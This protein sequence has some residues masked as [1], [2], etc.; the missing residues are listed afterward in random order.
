M[1]GD[2]AAWNDPII[3]QGLAITLR[4]VR[5][6]TDILCNGSD[7]S[8]AAFASYGDE[9]RERMR[10]ASGGRRS[11]QN[12]TRD[13]IQPGWCSPPSSYNAVR[14]TDPVLGGVQLTVFVGPDNV[15]VESFSQPIVDR[16]LA[17]K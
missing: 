3:G 11:G 6:V 9:R 16:I 4:D 13:H 5:I 17:L 12:R 7:W 8:A 15:S 1:I 2:A 10:R 14:R